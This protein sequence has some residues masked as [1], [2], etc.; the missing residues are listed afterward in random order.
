MKVVFRCPPEL[1][2]VLPAPVPAKRAVPGWRK[3]MAPAAFSEDVGAEVRTVKHCPPFVDAMGLGFLVP[4]PVELRV[5][6]GRFEWEW[7]PPPSAL[8]ALPRSPLGFHVAEQLEGAPFRP[9]DRMAIKFTSFWTIETEPGVSL[10]VTHPLNREDLPF[11]TLAGLV[12]TDRYAD[13]AIQFPAL[14]LDEGYAGTLARGTPVAQC[15]P[16]PRAALEVETGVLDGE[17]A[18]RFRTIMDAV[19]AAPG[20][21][22]RR[23]RAPKP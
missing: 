8:G 16:V 13:G 15:V 18:E 20:A 9:D 5:E 2:D 7:D 1:R 10:L 4:L 23:Y 21:Y 3:S 12:D 17:H 19:N 11:R 6:R 22:R 14:W